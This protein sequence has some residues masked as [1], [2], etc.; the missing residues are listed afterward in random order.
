M[1]IE[2]LTPQQGQPLPPIEWNYEDVKKWVEEGLAR[3]EGLVYDDTQMA[4]AKKDRATLNKLT[5]AIDARRREM[6]QLYLQPYELFEAQAKEITGMI[7]TQAGKIDLQ[8][9][10]Y[11]AQKKNEKRQKIEAELYAPMIG[12][13]AELVPYDRLHDAKW[14]NVTCSMGTVSEELGKKIDR[15]TSG[16]EAIGRI[17]LPK[18]I[19]EHARVKFLENFDLAAALS[20]VDFVK[21]QREQLEA[22]SARQKEQEAEKRALSSE[23][24]KIHPE[25]SNGLKTA[26][27]GSDEVAP[28]APKWGKGEKVH[29]VAFGVYATT[30]QLTRLRAAMDEIGIKPERITRKDVEKWL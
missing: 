7:K 14:L 17:D 26:Q 28:E 29:A 23:G 30:E 8:I 18:D 20:Y 1:E 22:L 19:V 3:Y 13:L 24:D 12:G 15:I 25:N 5:Q 11:E 10:T 21:R 2:I 16:L 4:T 27:N 6:K 9:K